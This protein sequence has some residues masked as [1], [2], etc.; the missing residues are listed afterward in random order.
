G[1]GG[2]TGAGGDG[3]GGGTGPGGDGAGG[4]GAGGEGEGGAGAGVGD[5]VGAAALP[6]LASQPEPPQHAA[7]IAAVSINAPTRT[8]L[9]NGLRGFVTSLTSRSTSVTLFVAPGTTWRMR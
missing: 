4:D 7:S 1:A 3:A 9:V 2:G 8:R 6:W 5:G